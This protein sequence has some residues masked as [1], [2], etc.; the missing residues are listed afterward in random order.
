MHRCN[1]E[2]GINAARKGDRMEKKF[3]VFATV[4]ELNR[5]AAAQREEGDLEALKGLA[6]ENGLDEADAEDYMDGLADVLATPLMAAVGKLTKEAEELK[7][8]SQMA[9]WKDYVVQMCTEDGALCEAVFRPKKRLM[10]VLAA[11]LKKASEN[12]VTVDRRIVRAA[13]LPDSAAHIGMCGRDE[14]RRIINDYYLG[15]QSD[16]SIQGDQ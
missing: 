4:E 7:L 14:L 8:K 10:D 15:G 12:R 3:G 5:A 11:G 13:D 6:A 1:K 16:E 9:D 2:R